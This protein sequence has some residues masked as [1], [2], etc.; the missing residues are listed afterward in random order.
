MSR[1][2]R[3]LLLVPFVMLLVGCWDIQEAQSNNYITALGIDYD[4]DKEEFIAYGQLL[5]FSAIVKQEGGSSS[6]Q[7]RTWVGKG[8][9][10]T[11][12]L[13]MNDLYK[14]AQQRTIWGHIASIVIGEK[15]LEKGI[16][17]FEDAISRYRE[18]RFTPWI[19]GT[20]A[21][22]PELFSTPAFFGMSALNTM[23]L[24]PRE[25]F[26]QS[27]WIAPLRYT[28]FI[29]DVRESGRTA[30]LPS[31]A[32][33]RTQ[34]SKDERPE[35]KMVLDGAFMISRMESKGWIE[36]TKLSGLRWVTEETVRSPILLEEQGKPLAVISL[37]H[38]KID[39]SESEVEGKPR[40]TISVKMDGNVMDWIK[41]VE[42]GKLKQI[43]ERQLKREIEETYRNGIAIGADVYQLEYHT[44]RNRTSSWKHLRDKGAF[45][46]SGE[47]LEDVR[48]SILIRHTG[49]KK[50]K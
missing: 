40:Y 29:A 33:N 24:E 41:Y 8:T 47:S 32:I 28:T 5:S 18:I 27:S 6:Q 45:P 3:L 25:I 39:I 35:R 10:A 17:Q 48:V 13:A 15:A 36:R 12:N 49:M 2:Y 42:E 22:I 26:E 23:M 14:T 43:A 34:W 9:G 50:A 38:P 30:V 21:S 11:L 44:Y 16:E 31:L 4:P 20:K 46:L 7:A 1:R 19:F 37:G